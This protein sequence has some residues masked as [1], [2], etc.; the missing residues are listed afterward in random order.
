LK[1]LKQ[2]KMKTIVNGNRSV[3]VNPLSVIDRIIAA[4]ELS[5]T[6]HGEATRSYQAVAQVLAKWIP[7]INVAIHPQGSMRQGTTIKPMNQEQFDLDM[8]CWLELDAAQNAPEAVYERVWT[9]LGKD[10]TYRGMRNK[11]SRCIE[12]I[13]PAEKQFHLDVVPAVPASALNGSIYV[14]D[15]ELKRWCHSSPLVFCD[16][17]FKK[18]G[19]TLPRIHKIAIANA[20]DEKI[21]NASA[22]VEP[23]PEYGAFEK[24][25]LQRVVQLLKRDRDV[26]FQN[27]TKYRPASVLLTTLTTHSYS[28]VVQDSVSDLFEFVLKVVA[29]LPDFIEVTGPVN[30]RTFAVFNP[31]NHPENFAEKWTEEHYARFRAWHTRLMTGLQC[32]AESRGQGMDVLL[33]RISDNFGKQAVIKA[34]DALGADTRALHEEGRLR[35]SS[36]LVGTVGAIVPSTINFGSET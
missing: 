4:L 24:T 31:V 36:G 3:A 26:H 6:Q 27:D 13:Y 33:N 23:M 35:V 1:D 9:A 15:Q 12:L 20:R 14:P 30:R 28:S 16:K 8:L 17:W 7:G 22:Y 21:I 25:P 19:E 29:K 10:E 18:A 5:H 2:K 11:K 32:I 34:A